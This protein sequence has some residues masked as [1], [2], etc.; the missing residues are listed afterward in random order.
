MQEW[1]DRIRSGFIGFP[2]S[3]FSSMNRSGTSMFFLS[4]SLE[5]AV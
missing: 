4:L 1:K 5:G 2:F 3:S